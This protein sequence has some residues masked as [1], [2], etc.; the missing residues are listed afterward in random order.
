M[1]FA[2]SYPWDYIKLD[3]SQLQPRNGY[4]DMTLTQ[5][6]D[7][8]SY[9]D[10][11][12]LLVVDHSPD[13]D[14]YSTKGTYIYN[15]EG[16]G[17]I[18]SVSK[19]PVPPISC[20]NGEEDCLPQISKLDGIYTTGNEFHYDTLELNLGSLSDAEEIKLIVAGIIVY[21]KGEIQGEWAAKFVDQ[22]GVK[23]F[24]PPY[25]EV[26]DENGNWVRVPENRQFPLLDVTS[27][28]FVVNLTGI[29]P[30]NDYSLRINKT[31]HFIG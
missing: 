26:K 31:L 16:Q 5:V 3:R 24:P 12:Q 23:P 4:Y 19:N 17:R 11:V 8:I 7:E 18:I 9:I 6:W 25:M 14:V 13:V 1:V 30:T 15:L 29:F 21:S 28:C 22:P 27:D 10:S 20:T 2:Y